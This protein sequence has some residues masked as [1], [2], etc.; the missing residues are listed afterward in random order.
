VDVPE[1]LSFARTATLGTSRQHEPAGTAAC[2]RSSS[3]ASAVR[4]DGWGW[5]FLR[6][7]AGAR[8]PVDR[9]RE[10][11]MSGVVLVGR[12]LFS[13][14]FLGAGIGHLRNAPAMTEYARYKRLPAARA[15]VI[16]SGCSS[17]WVA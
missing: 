9:Q 12:I 7:S 6:A 1:P 14:L 2:R 4:L 8:A 3:V 15:G 16:G 13:A 5:R 10:G 17:S 11:L